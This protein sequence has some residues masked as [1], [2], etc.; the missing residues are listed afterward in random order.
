MKGL[1]PFHSTVTDFAKFLGLST[2]VP[3]AH[4]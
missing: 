1:L 2:S 3:L 4:A